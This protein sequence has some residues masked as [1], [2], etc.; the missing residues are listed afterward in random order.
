MTK[1]EILEAAIAVRG[2]MRV[3]KKTSWEITDSLIDNLLISRGEAD[4]IDKLTKEL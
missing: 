4:K 3:L 2:L 1:G